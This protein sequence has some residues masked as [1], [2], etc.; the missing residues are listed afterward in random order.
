MGNTII[1]TD[2]LTRELQFGAERLPKDTSILTTGIIALPFS[3]G[4][5]GII[6]SI[7]TLVNSSA[8]L[9]AYNLNPSRYK[10]SSLKKVKAGRVCAIISLSL[11][12]AAI[13]VVIVV[14]ALN[15]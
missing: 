5:V 11:F 9:K 1:D 13:L 3:L 10:E 4:I 14:V 15:A 8:A 6:L 2:V 7:L 12:V